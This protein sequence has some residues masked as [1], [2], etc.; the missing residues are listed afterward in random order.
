MIAK[1]ET[2]AQLKRE[3]ICY[4][5]SQASIF[6]G[7]PEQYLKRIASYCSTRILARNE[8]LFRQHD[9]VV[10]FFILRSGL[11]NV[12]RINANQEEQIIH[13]LHPGESFAERAIASTTGY[14]AHAQAV[15]ES[16]VIL[17][18]LKNSNNIRKKTLIL[19]GG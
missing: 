4:S 7:L 5:L 2:I 3:A 16:E 9:P 13:L 18:L 14:P 1:I 17:I 8:Y 12:H 11:I 10:G 6:K 15:E 19:H